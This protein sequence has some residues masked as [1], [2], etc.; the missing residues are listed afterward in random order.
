MPPEWSTPHNAKLDY[1]LA[2]IL[3]RPDMT[4]LTQHSTVGLQLRSRP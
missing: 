1:D 3:P 4:S 2:L